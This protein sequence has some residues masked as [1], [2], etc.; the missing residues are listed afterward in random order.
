MLKKIVILGST[1]SVG[2]SV[3]QVVSH[4]SGQIS[5]QGLAALQNIS[6]LQEQVMEYKPQIAAV[7]SKEHAY[8][9][10]KSSS[11]PIR[12]GLEG[13]I[14][15][16]TSDG[17]DLII[18]AMTGIRGLLPAIQA[19]KARKNIAIA[20]KELLV[21]AGDLIMELSREMGTRVFPLD[22]EHNAIFQCL[23]GNEQK[24]VSR[25]ILTASGGPFHAFSKEQMR[26]I[27]VADALHHPVW[28][29]GDKISID[30]STLMN[31]GLEMIEA[32]TLFGVSVEKIDVIIHPQSIVHSLVEFVDGCL[33][34]QM[35][36]PSMLTPIQYVLTYPHRQSSSLPFFSFTEYPELTFIRP[37]IEKFRC[38]ALAIEAMKIG[39]TA[40]GFLSAANEVLVARFLS[41]SISWISISEKLEYLMGSYSHKANYSLET[42]ISIDQEARELAR[43]I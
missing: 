23:Q 1:G 42:I 6:L 22:S 7:F 16:A 32:K 24:E 21:S 37:D 5:V 11:I 19:I 15:L 13:L 25:L 2:K 35:G 41:G 38:L 8:D 29:M 12:A 26:S 20:N 9:M 14:E 10:Q 3:L 27:T 31:K 18:F 43:D 28:K 40:P 4:L 39:G 17:A 33:L 30:S 34:A 36:R